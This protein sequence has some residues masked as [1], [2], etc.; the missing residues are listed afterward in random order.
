MEAR[1]VRLIWKSIYS[2]LALT[3]VTAEMSVNLQDAEGAPR[4]KARVGSPE[5]PSH[6]CPSGEQLVCSPNANCV[7]LPTTPTPTPKPTATPRPT[8][9]PTPP[10]P[11]TPTPYPCPYTQNISQNIVNGPLSN[12]VPLVKVG[13]P[14][15]LQKRLITTYIAAGVIAATQGYPGYYWDDIVNTAFLAPAAWLDFNGFCLIR[16]GVYYNYLIGN[17]AGCGT[18]VI[19][20]DQECK[21]VNP[22]QVLADPR[23]TIGN[24]ETGLVLLYFSSSPISLLWE[25]DADVEAQT[26]LSQ[27]PIEPSA[28]ALD[29]FTWKASAKTPLLV[30]DPEHRGEIKSADQLFGNWTFGG[31]KSASLAALGMGDVQPDAWDHGYQA[32]ATLDRNFDGEISGSELEP[33]GLW[34]DRNQNALSDPG[35]V[36][37]ITSTGVT[38][39]YFNAEPRDAKTGNIV[40]KRGYTRVIDG[41]TVTRGSVDWWS[42]KAPS[43]AQLLQKHTMGQ[44]V[45]SRTAE[46]AAEPHKLPASAPG[47]APLAAPVSSPAAAPAYGSPKSAPPA[48]AAT[49]EGK[50][51]MEFHREYTKDPIVGG[52]SWRETTSGRNSQRRP[53]GVLNIAR[54]ADGTYVVQSLVEVAAPNASAPFA[55]AITMLMMQGK[56]SIDQRGLQKLSFSNGKEDPNMPALESEAVFNGDEM[57]G[58]TTIFAV[59]GDRHVQAGRYSW[60]ATRTE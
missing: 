45:R 27:F 22:L 20:F 3:I 7:C 37:S 21:P 58:T 35:E 44:F 47:I 34:F 48:A 17:F 59:Q 39:L 14:E 28:G 57:V 10:P 46:L 11:P 49:S 52:W 54:N 53:D 19:Y 5:A 51:P 41:K 32:L 30:Y 9:T 55:S 38:A 2:V 16:G 1:S 6:E 24:I 29:W 18:A 23:C 31:Q 42:E 4:T 43:Y 56:L 60:V 25:D 50:T 40:A 12:P 33:L 15:C 26:V 13:G 36:E 8:A